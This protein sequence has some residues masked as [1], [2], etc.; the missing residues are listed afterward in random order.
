[1][2]DI[3]KDM[4]VIVAD[5]MMIYSMTAI[6]DRALPD[7]TDGLKPLI[8]KILYAMDKAGYNSNKEY[9]KTANP[10]S[11]TMK[12]HGHGDVSIAGALALITDK[13]ESLLHPLIDGD[14][15]F[16]KS[17]NTDKYS[18]PRYT[19][20]RLNSFSEE[21][22]LK[23]VNKGA[24]TFVEESGHKQ[25]IVLP[26]QIP[27]IL[28]KQNMGIAVGMATNIPSFNLA[29]VVDLTIKILK[30][31]KY[32]KEL[33]PD[34]SDGGEYLYNKQELVNI[35]T[36]GKG[37]VVLRSKWRYIEE[38]SC[39]EVYEIPSTTTVNVIIDK[40]LD[41]VKK[42]S[43]KE[44]TDI[45][46]ET[47]YDK[48][49]KRETLKLT[50]DIKKKAD[51]NVVMA[52]LFKSSPLQDSFSVN[53]NMLV[54]GE[55]KVLG[56]EDTIKTWLDIRREI[57]KRELTIDLNA[58]RKEYKIMADLMKVINH[59]DEIVVIIKQSNTDLEVKNALKSKFCLTE[60]G[61]NYISE[62]KLKNLNRGWIESKTKYFEDVKEKGKNTKLAIENKD[63]LDEIIINQLLSAKNKFGKN[64]RTQVVK[65][66]QEVNV[67]SNKEIES[68]NCNVAVSSEGY[69]KKYLRKTD[70]HKVKDGDKITYINSCN[71]TDS[72]LLITNKQNA[73]NVKLDN[74]KQC[75]PSE[76]G[77]YYP[78]QLSFD[79]DERIILSSLVNESDIVIVYSDG[80]I[81]RI[82]A[83][84]YESTR[85]KLTNAYANK[86]IRY[87]GLYQPN[88][89]IGLLSTDGKLSIYNLDNTPVK[90]GRTSGGV[91]AKKFRECATLHKAFIVDDGVPQEI[92]DYYSSKNACIGNFIRP[93]DEDYFK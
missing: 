75:L 61:A 51:P 79:K 18:A 50:I 59:I 49:L 62:L 70:S 71:N 29:E 87:I 22:L 35:F 37:K 6:T 91:T 66:V 16:G 88:Q 64:R 85:T 32:D 73:Y 43:L 72:L 3:K 5:N 38:Y 17:Y 7:I 9:V 26:S 20:C 76:L 30:G 52:K 14:G 55:P 24:I 80:L 60:E 68:Y 84:S 39:I 4:N 74:I 56:V 40:V 10:I 33:I 63:K 93:Q 31:E 13:N 21:M 81:A 15:A 45:R 92:I 67:D 27:H 36:K 28:I 58:L 78:T 34:F 23:N 47:G 89:L 12:I 8:R 2:N 25:P 11:E 82:Q 90:K 48:K 44:V 83:S 86:D 77:T 53:M 54:N 65:D 46:D 1:M 42:G 57:V 41:M 19:F 69:I